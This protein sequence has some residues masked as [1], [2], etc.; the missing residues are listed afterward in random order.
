MWYTGG[1]NSSYDLRIILLSLSPPDLHR[2]YP[3]DGGEGEDQ[4]PIGGKR[5]KLDKA[6]SF[7]VGMA[8]GEAEMGRGV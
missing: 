8:T 5:P 3:E 1:D 6:G 7:D 4:S 2:T